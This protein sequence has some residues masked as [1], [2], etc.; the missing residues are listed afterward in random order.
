MVRFAWTPKIEA[1]NPEAER[2]QPKWLHG[3]WTRK[4]D[5]SAKQL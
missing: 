4:L 1:L 5:L 2:L 3:Y